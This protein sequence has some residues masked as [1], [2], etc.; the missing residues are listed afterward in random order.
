MGR[1]PRSA[2]ER[3]RGVAES[4]SREHRRSDM[5]VRPRTLAERTSVSSCARAGS[6]LPPSY[7]M[8]GDG[9]FSP[10][11]R[12]LTSDASLLAA[13]GR[14]RVLG[15]PS[16]R[17]YIGI[18]QAPQARRQRRRLWARYTCDRGL[19]RAPVGLGRRAAL[20]WRA[21]IILAGA[22]PPATGATSSH[23]PITVPR[24]SC[25]PRTAALMRQRLPSVR[26]SE[27]APPPGG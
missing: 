23:R 10:P 22:A 20:A 17:S 16:G 11:S 14:R 3:M 6:S 21:S 2:A 26:A 5:D 1:S 15:W 13:A 19:T 18:G 12:Q 27:A 9:G 24:P 8:H 4:S 25:R 7:S